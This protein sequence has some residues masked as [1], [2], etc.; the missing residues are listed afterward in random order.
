MVKT[1]KT[2]ET[3]KEIGYGMDVPGTKIKEQELW[4]TIINQAK[5]TPTTPPKKE[6]TIPNK[7][8]I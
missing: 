3:V 6:V 8:N 5:R 2:F 4:K 1:I 7:K